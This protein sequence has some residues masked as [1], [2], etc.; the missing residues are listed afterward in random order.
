MNLSRLQRSTPICFITLLGIVIL[1]NYW[2]IFF[3]KFPCYWQFWQ[4]FWYTP[5]QPQPFY[6]SKI[7]QQV[8]GKLIR[9]HDELI[10]PLLSGRLLVLHVRHVLWFYFIIVKCH[11]SF[12]FVYVRCPSAILK[13]LKKFSQTSFL[14]FI[15]WYI[16][17][18]T[19]TSSNKALFFSSQCV[20]CFSSF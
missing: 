9:V 12:L 2:L 13:F 20:Y 14:F 18:V 7:V 11:P 16:F 17:S 15:F 19:F 1:C 6:A 8:F 3:K 10:K 5:L 4:F